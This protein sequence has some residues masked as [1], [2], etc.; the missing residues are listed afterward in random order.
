[1]DQTAPRLL[2]DGGIALAAGAIQEECAFTGQSLAL[3]SGIRSLN[4][5][6]DGDQRSH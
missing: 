4:V 6:F 2:L 5:L 3:R 1:M